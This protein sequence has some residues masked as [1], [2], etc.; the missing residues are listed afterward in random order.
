MKCIAPYREKKGLL[1]LL[2]YITRIF[3][4]RRLTRIYIHED[5][6]L[7]IISSSQERCGAVVRTPM[8]ILRIVSTSLTTC[9]RLL[10]VSNQTNYGTRLRCFHMQ[11]EKFPLTV[12]SRAT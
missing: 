12:V 9:S 3:M 8:R 4:I 2:E 6:I 5:H 7:A 10:G 1:V 11:I